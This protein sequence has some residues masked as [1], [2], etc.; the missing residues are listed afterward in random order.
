MIF[1]TVIVCFIGSTLVL[2]PV[3]IFR[4]Q[5][6]NFAMRVVNIASVWTNIGAAFIDITVNMLQT[7]SVC[8]FFQ[9]PVNTTFHPVS[10]SDSNFY[11]NS[12]FML[13]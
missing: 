7:V 4:V 8:R 9:Q 2:I 6:R 10:E 13:H 1:A 11:V 12:V 3:N 5:L